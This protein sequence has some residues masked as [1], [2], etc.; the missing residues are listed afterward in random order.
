M[1]YNC[2]P[3]FTLVFKNSSLIFQSIQQTIITFFLLNTKCETRLHM[4]KWN[5]IPQSTRKTRSSD[6]SCCKKHDSCDQLLYKSK[7]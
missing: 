3:T 7:I 1:F 5:T 4:G 2:F 6:D